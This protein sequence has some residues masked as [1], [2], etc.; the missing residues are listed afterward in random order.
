M[1][2]T[3]TLFC[4][5]PPCVHNLPWS[6][7]CILVYV[8]G[9]IEQVCK[10][11]KKKKNFGWKILWFR[12]W[13]KCGRK[14]AAELY[15]KKQ[16]KQRTITLR[17]TLLQSWSI[18]GFQSLII[19]QQ[20]CWCISMTK[21]HSSWARWAKRHLHIY[22]IIHNLGCLSNLKSWYAFTVRQW[23]H[24]IRINRVAGE[25]SVKKKL[26]TMVLKS[27]HLRGV[28]HKSNWLVLYKKRAWI[29]E[30]VMVMT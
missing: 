11:L 22:R 9:A 10:I 26:Q 7:F 5:F 24:L 12:A 13:V 30:E 15:K 21:T 29:P 14:M 25:V 23:L 3:F 4:F 6:N 1:K 8:G 17:P 19:E 2:K 28:P 16:K 18:T 20:D 27:K